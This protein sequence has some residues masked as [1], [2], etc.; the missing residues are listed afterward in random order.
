MVS[1]IGEEMRIQRGL[2][3]LARMIIVG[4]GQLRLTRLFFSLWIVKRPTEGQ[5][6]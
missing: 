3:G 2:S 5:V 6:E 1:R 4:C